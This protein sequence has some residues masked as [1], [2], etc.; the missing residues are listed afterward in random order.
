MTPGTPTTI[1]AQDL[2]KFKNVAC[3]KDAGGMAGNRRGDRGGGGP[4]Q[5]GRAL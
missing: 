4:G 3:V 2:G 5:Y 1:L